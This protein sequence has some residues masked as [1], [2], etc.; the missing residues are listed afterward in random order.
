M[1][2]TT[3]PNGKNSLLGE[4]LLS[5]ARA[6]EHIQEAIV[7]YGVEIMRPYANEMIR[8]YPMM[9]HLTEILDRQAPKD[10]SKS[11]KKGA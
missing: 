8:P 10:S 9:T 11:P 4:F 5:L 2:E 1:A 7:L 6:P 3:E